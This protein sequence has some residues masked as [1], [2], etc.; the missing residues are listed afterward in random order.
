MENI[1]KIPGTQPIN[2]I[3]EKFQKTHK[4]LGL[5]IDEFGGVEGV[6]SLEDIIEEVF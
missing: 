3:L 5:V 1:I 6:I 2:T 4:H